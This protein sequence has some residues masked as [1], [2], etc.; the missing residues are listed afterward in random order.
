[1]TEH[2]LHSLTP[3]GHPEPQTVT[4]GPVTITEVV[5][6]ALASL[7]SRRGREADVAAAAKTLD[8][9]LPGPNG[10]ASGAVFA[11]FWLGP[12]QW[13]IEAPFAS[14]ED[15]ATRLLSTF[16]DAASITEQTDG[17]VRFDLAGANLPDLLERLCCLDTRAM[18]AGTATRTVIDHLGCHVIWRAPEVFSVVGPRSSAGSLHHAL[19][20]AAKS[21]F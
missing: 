3:L 1:M 21:V 2:R 6:V 10:S 16:G 9:P 14:H 7:A 5:T 17:W 8:I 12:E 18:S 13:M 20:T 19:T 11:A 4:I 15:I